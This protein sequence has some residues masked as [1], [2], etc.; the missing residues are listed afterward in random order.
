VSPVSVR[1]LHRKSSLLSAFKSVLTSQHPCSSICPH[2]PLS[3]TWSDLVRLHYGVLVHP[4][5]LLHSIWP[6]D[7]LT[8]YDDLPNLPGSH[9]SNWKPLATLLRGANADS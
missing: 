1:K 8:R 2:S 5:H 6:Y 7:V 9:I 4:V 3:M